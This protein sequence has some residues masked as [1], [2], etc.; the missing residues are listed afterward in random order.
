MKL[1]FLLDIV[2]PWC[3]IGK[4]HY[5]NV[6]IK[7]KKKINNFSWKPFFLNPDMPIIGVNRQQYLNNKFGD[8]N[9]AAKTYQNILF[10]GKKV[11]INFN[12]NKISIMPN[13]LKAMSLISSIKD[14][15]KASFFIDDLFKA[16][17][18]K[19]EDLGCSNILFKYGK[20]YLDNLTVPVINN[21]KNNK[22]LLDTDY[23][24]KSQGV[25]GVPAIIINSKHYLE[26]AQETTKLES[27]FNELP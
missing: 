7:Y 4:K 20:N 8:Q 11:G 13:S 12:F 1:D 17:F 27:I 22:N 19:G 14:P 21:K 10:A 24:F 3:Y 25:S 5:D 9:N 6:D 26:G 16:F 2:C 15:E 18:I 23:K